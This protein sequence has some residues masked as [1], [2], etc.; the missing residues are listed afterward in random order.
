MVRLRQSKQTHNHLLAVVS[1]SEPK[2]DSLGSAT[3]N[4]PDEALRA[5]SKVSSAHINS[6]QQNGIIVVRNVLSNT[7]N[8]LA[9]CAVACR[10]LRA[11]AC[12]KASSKNSKESVYLFF[13]QKTSRET[14]ILSFE[15][16]PA[17]VLVAE[18]G[19]ASSVQGIDWKAALIP[20]QASDPAAIYVDDLFGK[21]GETPTTVVQ[22]SKGTIF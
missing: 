6:F 12:A 13:E 8:D 10:L 15:L 17:D 11:P 4:D 22:W 18:V 19:I 21:K 5:A 9:A 20:C 14:T 2:Q 1:A 3:S 16:G 7:N